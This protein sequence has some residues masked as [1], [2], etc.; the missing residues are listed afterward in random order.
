MGQGVCKALRKGLWVFLRGHKIGSAAILAASNPRSGHLQVTGGEKT[1]ARLCWKQALPT[2]CCDA[3]AAV[4]HDP[5]AVAEE[6]GAE[7]AFNFVFQLTVG[8]FGER[9]H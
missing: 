5:F 9:S 7:F 6:D 8:G 3:Q 2:L 4:V 1:K